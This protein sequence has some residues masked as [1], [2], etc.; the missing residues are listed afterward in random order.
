MEIHYRRA[1]AMGIPVVRL[2]VDAQNLAWMIL[3]PHVWPLI[4][5]LP[6]NLRSFGRYSRRG[7][8]FHDRGDSHRRYGPVWAL[9]TPREI[10]LIVAE[11]EAIH[12]IFQ[13]RTDFVRPSIMYKV[14]EVYGPCISTAT[15][16]DWARHRKI[17][18]TPFNENIMSYAWDESVEQ[19][20]QMLEV[21]AGEESNEITSVS[22][23]TRTVSLNVLAATGFRKSYPFRTLQD[24]DGPASYRDSLQTIL[25]NAILLMVAPRNLLSMPFAPKSWQVLGKAAKDFK[26][27]MLTM[28]HDE[29][30]ALNEGKPGSG[31]LMTTLVRAMDIQKASTKNETSNEPQKG[32]SVDEIFGNIFVINFAGHDTTANTLSFVML[33]LAAYPEVQDWVAEELEWIPEDLQGQYSELYPKLNRCRALML[34]TLRIFPPVPALPKLTYGSPQPLKLKDKTILIPQNSGLLINLISTQNSSTYWAD[35]FTWRPA[36]WVTNSPI[37]ESDAALL[38]EPERLNTPKLGSSAPADE[39]LVTPSRCTYFP[40]AEGGHSCPGNKFSQVEF[41]AVIAKLLR[42]YRVGAVPK[43]GET[44]EQTR[45]RILGITQDVDLQLLLRMRDADQVRLMCVKA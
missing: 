34:E 24:Q 31:S 40:W 1:S 41:V 17:V 39:R 4:E 32:L 44:S 29:T 21:W 20:R 15:G 23:D 30:K 16:P 9:A 26:N 13:R 25:D 35:P 11:S 10:T 14:L 42:H 36:R 12:S 3:E 45:S 43:S 18:A 19:S 22:K 2:C 6:F 28:L 5:K 8:L 7:W 37:T 33:L 38:L 27:H